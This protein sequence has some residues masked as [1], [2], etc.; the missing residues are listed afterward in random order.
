MDGNFISINPLWITLLKISPSTTHYLTISHMQSY[1]GHIEK[2]GGVGNSKV[3]V[4]SKGLVTW[5]KIIRVEVVVSAQ[6][7]STII[8]H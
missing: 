8:L 2:G 4:T 3:I 5:V 6:R 7:V 1:L